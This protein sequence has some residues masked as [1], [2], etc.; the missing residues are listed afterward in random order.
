MN[1]I[2]YPK[3]TTYFIAYDNENIENPSYGMVE[4]EQVMTTGREFLFQT[5]NESEYL[6]KLETE[7]DI[8]E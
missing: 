8:S 3:N 6:S 2:K 4:P 1:E 7:F 5:E